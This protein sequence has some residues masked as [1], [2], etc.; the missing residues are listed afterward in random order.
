MHP[1]SNGGG[2][3]LTPLC[4]LKSCPESWRWKGHLA[5]AAAERA[6]VSPGTKGLGKGRP[7]RSRSLGGSSLSGETRV[8]TSS[9]YGGAKGREKAGKM[10]RD[11]AG[12]PP[13]YFQPS[14]LPLSRRPS[15]AQEQAAG[16]N[17]RPGSRVPPNPP[18][19]PALPPLRTTISGRKPRWRARQWGASFPCCAPGP[20]TP[21]PPRLRHSGHYLSS[22]PLL[23]SETICSPVP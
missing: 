8:A 4:G 2:R 9:R 19:T 20:R 5:V 16:D 11:C 12:I 21:G 6:S 15:P 3:V 10:R 13:P 18:R 14:I 23:D 1:D 7:A 22:S 17:R